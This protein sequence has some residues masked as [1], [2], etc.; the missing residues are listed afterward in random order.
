MKGIAFNLLIIRVHRGQAAGSY[1]SKKTHASTIRFMPQTVKEVP[2]DVIGRGYDLDGSTV[3]DMDIKG[4]ART[5]VTNSAVA[6]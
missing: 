1:I 4:D 6:V 5:S 2:I 3:L